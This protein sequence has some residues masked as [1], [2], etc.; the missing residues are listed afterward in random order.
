MANVSSWRD[1]LLAFRNTPLAEAVEAIN[2]YRDG[3]IILAREIIAD[4]PVNGIF[5]TDQID[6]AVRQIQQLLQLQ[7]RHLPSNVILIG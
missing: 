3:K 1:G 6:N 4:R 5:H 7:I 2:R